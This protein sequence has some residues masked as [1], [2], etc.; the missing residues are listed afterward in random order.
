MTD[1][2][3][4]NIKKEFDSLTTEEIRDYS[5]KTSYPYVNL[6]LNIQSNLNMGNMLRTSHLCGCSKVVIFGRRH[7]D[8]R[9]AVGVYNYT[10]VERISGLKNHNQDLTTLLTDLD[11]AFDD[12]IFYKFINENNYLPVFVEQSSDSIIATPSNIHTIITTSKTINKTPIF[13]Y[14]NEGTG[15]PVNILNTAGRFTN[16]YILELYQKGALQSYNVSNSCA[17]VSYLVSLCFNDS[18]I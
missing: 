16:Y 5:I 18:L 4:R 8:K 12:E 13:I 9:S 17:I 11:Y 10:N 3:G 7:Y 1:F 14:G 6:A 15:I 2:L